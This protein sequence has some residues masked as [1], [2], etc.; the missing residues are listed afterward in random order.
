MKT[1][2][3]TVQNIE[4]TFYAKDS[5]GNVIELHKGDSI[6]SNMLVYG[7]KANSSSSKIGI[8]MLNLNEVVNLEGTI[9]QQFDMSLMSDT[10][11]SEGLEPENIMAALDKSIYVDEKQENLEDEEDIANIDETAGGDEQ[12]VTG[13]STDDVFA[14]RDASAVD[15]VAGLRNASFALDSSPEVKEPQ[16]FETDIINIAESTGADINFSEET[17]NSLKDNL[18]SGI[19]NIGAFPSN[20]FEMTDFG[21]TVDITSITGEDTTTASE[22]T[23]DDTPTN[24]DTGEDTTTNEDTGDDTTTDTNSRDNGDSIAFPVNFPIDIM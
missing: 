21:D 14:D 6:S 3:G 16:L 23:G 22:N 18:E 20:L 15:V 2:I 9:K 24:E 4:G 10:R 11:E 5:S 19:E 1:I 7:D 13:Q 8:K 12:A 17:I